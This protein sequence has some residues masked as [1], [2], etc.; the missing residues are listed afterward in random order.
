MDI[1]AR[2]TDIKQWLLGRLPGSIRPRRL[3][4]AAGG[5]ALGFVAVNLVL[6]GVFLHRTYPNTR[7]GAHSIGAISY[8]A[9]APR[10]ARLGLIPPS[11]TLIQ[12]STQN[13]AVTPR[14]LGVQ[15]D[16]AKI[17]AT[18][19]HRAWL[20]VQNLFIAHDIPV[21]TEVNRPVLARKLQAIAAASKQAP[22]DARVVLQNNRFSLATAA[23]GSQLDIGRAEAVISR[24]VARGQAT[25][26]LPVAAI[27]PAVTEASLQTDLRQLQAGQSVSLKY[28]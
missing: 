14:E 10:A 2:I 20:P 12:A 25:V 3:A 8:N 13:L 21:Y 7:I 17:A 24:A 28:T 1:S 22:T 9:V 19:R 16:T 6:Y 27:R 26:R 23:D 4:V 18:A 5:L 11:F 15:V